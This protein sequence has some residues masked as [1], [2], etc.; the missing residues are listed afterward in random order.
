MKSPTMLQEIGT[1]N[2]A[3]KDDIYEKIHETIEGWP[4][5]KKQA[6]NDNLAISRYSKKLVINNKK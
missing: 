4:D 1:N 6:Y 3:K 2:K 5:W